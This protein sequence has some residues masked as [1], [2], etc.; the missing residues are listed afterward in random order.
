M[1]T[2]QHSLRRRIT[3]AAVAPLVVSSLMLTSLTTAGAA[4]P[5]SV[6]AGSPHA[7]V[8][9]ATAVQNPAGVL[10]AVVPDG[11]NVEPMFWH[12]VLNAAVG[13]F[14]GGL[15][16]W[17]A[18]QAAGWTAGLFAASSSSSSESSSSSCATPLDSMFNLAP[19]ADAQFDA[20]G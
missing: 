12:D 5:A 11:G 3:R 18:T 4:E 7:V 9:S 8:N 2:S 15:A 20:A 17:G 1:N 10:Q 19:Q 14:V 6:T 16:G 13:G